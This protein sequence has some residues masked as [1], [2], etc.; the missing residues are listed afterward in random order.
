VVPEELKLPLLH[1]FHSFA[2]A[3]KNKVLDALSKQFYWRNMA[4]DVRRWTRS[5]LKCCLRKT[6]QPMLSHTGLK[7][8]RFQ[9]PRVTPL[10]R[11]CLQPANAWRT[12]SGSCESGGSASPNT[13]LPMILFGYRTAAHAG[14]GISPYQATFARHPIMPLDLSLGMEKDTSGKMRRHHTT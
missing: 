10:R 4:D 8:C 2:H 7:P 3:G 12:S 1:Y 9:T 11:P 6:P 5:C 13:R 14:T